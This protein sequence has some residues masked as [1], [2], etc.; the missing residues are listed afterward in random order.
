MYV[1]RKI[2]ARSCKHYCNEKA[3]L[4]IRSVCV[5]PSYTACNAHAPYRHLWPSRSTISSHVISLRARFSKQ[6][7]C[8]LIFSTTFVETLL[9]SKKN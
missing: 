2:E 9:N 5:S 8:V 1:Q 3:V 6:K 7:M 4:H